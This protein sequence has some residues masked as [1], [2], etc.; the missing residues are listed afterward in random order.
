MSIHNDYGHQILH[1]QSERE[2]IRDAE[3]RRLLRELGDQTPRLPWWRRLLGV[4]AGLGVTSTAAAE[5]GSTGDRRPS[6]IAL[7]RRLAH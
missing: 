3:Q 7:R 4:G 6:G 5:A 1:H 2:L